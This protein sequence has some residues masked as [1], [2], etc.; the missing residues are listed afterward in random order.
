MIQLSKCNDTIEFA[1]V[2]KKPSFWKRIKLQL[3]IYYIIVYNAK[4]PVSYFVPLKLFIIFVVVENDLHSR[5]YKL[6]VRR[7]RWP[8]E[9]RTRI[10]YCYYIPGSLHIDHILVSRLTVTIVSWPAAAVVSGVVADGSG[11]NSRVTTAQLRRHKT[12][13]SAPK[14]KLWHNWN[15]NVFKQAAFCLLPFRPRRFYTKAMCVVVCVS[16][17]FFI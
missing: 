2:Q 1:A 7:R 13:L 10:C 15:N 8:S 4:I 12:A 17:N 14:T 6:F 16:A 9:Y 11:N 3:I 5:I